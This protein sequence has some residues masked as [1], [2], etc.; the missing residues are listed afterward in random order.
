MQITGGGWGGENPN[1]PIYV[2]GRWKQ[3]VLNDNTLSNIV[4]DDDEKAT[5]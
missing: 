1:V 5:C 3:S 4:F 2:H